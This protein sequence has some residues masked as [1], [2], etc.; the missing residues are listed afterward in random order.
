MKVL[1]LEM[2]RQQ[3]EVESQSLAEQL[4]CST[5]QQKGIILDLVLLMLSIVRHLAVICSIG[6]GARPFPGGHHVANCGEGGGRQK[7]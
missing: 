7:G 2:E 1:A 4:S 6:N 3:M 5:D